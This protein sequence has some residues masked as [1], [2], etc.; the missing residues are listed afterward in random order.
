[1]DGARWFALHAHVLLSADQI[2]RIEAAMA[3]DI[4]EYRSL[5]PP[6]SGTAS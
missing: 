3:E 1:M 4:T 5:M 2:D 6:P